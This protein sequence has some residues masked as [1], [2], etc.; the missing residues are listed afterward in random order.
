VAAGPGLGAGATVSLAVGHAVVWTV[1]GSTKLVS[2]EVT[3]SRQRGNTVEVL[4]SVVST[5]IERAQSESAQYQGRVPAPARLLDCRSG[6]R[7]RSALFE[8]QAGRTCWREKCAAQAG[9]RLGRGGLAAG[10]SIIAAAGVAT[11]LAYPHC[12]KVMDARWRGLSTM[13]AADVRDALRTLTAVRT[14]R[15]RISRPSMSSAV[16][17]KRRVAFSLPSSPIA[18]P[19]IADPVEAKPSACELRQTALS[20]PL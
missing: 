1:P 16:V 7:R 9:S 10:R 6:A 13:R 17:Q 20:G 15:R 14:R 11:I 19:E 3:T 12:M 8:R 5:G 2:V 18:A 4:T